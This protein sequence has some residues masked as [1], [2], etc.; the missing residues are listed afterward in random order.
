[1]F[2]EDLA[3]VS[4]ASLEE[5]EIGVR[6][7]WRSSLSLLVFVFV[8]AGVGFK[9]FKNIYFRFSE[10]EF[11]SGWFNRYQLQFRGS[12]GWTGFGSFF[13]SIEGNLFKAGGFLNVLRGVVMV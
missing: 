9:N 13:A 4:V 2:W 5:S 12:T 8:S 1:M 6:C 3:E 7:G 10:L 11:L